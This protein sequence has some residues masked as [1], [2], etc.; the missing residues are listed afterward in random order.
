MIQ[1]SGQSWW[2]G[3]EA[4]GLHPISTIYRLS[5]DG[6]MASVLLSVGLLPCKMST[7]VT[8]LTGEGSH[9]AQRL[10]ELSLFLRGLHN[11]VSCTRARHCQLTEL[12]KHGPSEFNKP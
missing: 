5:I 3:Q 7:V 10:G 9:L 2:P 12:G 11:S 8:L 6:F 4:V 1:H